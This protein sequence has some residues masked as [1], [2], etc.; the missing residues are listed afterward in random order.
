MS[1]SVDVSGLTRLAARQA[2]AGAGVFADVVAVTADHAALVAKVARGLMPVS[3]Q[4]SEHVVDTIGVEFLAAAGVVSARI[5]PEGAYGRRIGG[6]IEFGT[7]AHPIGPRSD[8]P[9]FLF[10]GQSHRVAPSKKTYEAS[11]EYRGADSLGRL[12]YVVQHPGTAPNPVMYE[13]LTHVLPAYVV[14]LRAA[15]AKRM[16]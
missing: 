11:S 2:A 8:G 9:G 13:S 4:G 10:W 1:V 5:G 6:F 15:A 3:D 16:S 12:H 7:E 14:A